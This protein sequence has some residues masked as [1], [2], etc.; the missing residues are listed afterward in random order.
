MKLPRPTALVG[1]VHLKAGAACAPWRCLFASDRRRR[2]VPVGQGYKKTSSVK[3]LDSIE[4]TPWVNIP[5]KTPLMLLSSF[6]GAAAAKAITHPNSVPLSELLGCKPQVRATRNHGNVS[7]ESCNTLCQRFRPLWHQLQQTAGATARRDGVWGWADTLRHG[8]GAFRGGGV[9]LPLLGQVHGQDWHACAQRIP[10]QD[11]LHSRAVPVLPA[12]HLL[13]ALWLLTV[14]AA[15][16]RLGMYDSHTH[17]RGRE[18]ESARARER[19]RE[20]E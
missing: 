9:F 4:L 10:G 18:R 14:H 5:L 15:G 1:A 8:S 17:E 3:N 16:P 13:C 7:A 19:E 20:S 11:S 2:M 6:V 12:S